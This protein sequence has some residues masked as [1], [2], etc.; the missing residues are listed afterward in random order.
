MIKYQVSGERG[1]KVQ[2][3]GVKYSCEALEVVPGQEGFWRRFDHFFTRDSKCSSKI[4]GLIE[5][6]R[7][8]DA[9]GKQKLANTKIDY[10]MVP[11]KDLD[12]MIKFSDVVFK[13]V[14]DNLENLKEQ[15][16]RVWPNSNAVKKA[17]RA[18][19][20]READKFHAKWK[21]DALDYM[22]HK[23][24]ARGKQLPEDV[25]CAGLGYNVQNLTSLAT[26]F[27]NGLSGHLRDLRRINEL[28]YHAGSDI[29]VGFG[30][31]SDGTVII[32][33]EEVVSAA[34]Q[35]LLDIL[36]TAIDVYKSID[37]FFFY[38]SK[39]V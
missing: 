38:L 30:T 31:A 16:N 9:E 24:D 22:S 4:K 2:P 11:A 13:F 8:L 36:G 39:E 32:T 25:T 27:S 21:I 15:V 29:K 28:I 20:K 7:T 34:A 12:Y 10:G 37:Y 17:V 5:N 1:F 14:G 33:F 3:R 23:R 6:L 18:F 19:A 26:R 35:P